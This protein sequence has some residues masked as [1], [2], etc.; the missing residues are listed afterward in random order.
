LGVHCPAP[1]FFLS[2]C[3]EFGKAVY[4]NLSLRPG[5]MAHVCDPSYSG[6]GGRRVAHKAGGAVGE[7]SVKP[8]LKTN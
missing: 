5:M 4:K 8:Y 1:A 3:P 6:R 2:F 7:Q